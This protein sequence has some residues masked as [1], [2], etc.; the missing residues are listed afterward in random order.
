LNIKAI[1]RSGAVRPSLSDGAIASGKTILPDYYGLDM[2]LAL[3]F[4]LHSP[5]AERIRRYVVG[6]VAAGSGKPVPAI[7][8]SCEAKAAVN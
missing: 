8:L 7:F 3:A 6:R 2:I 5:A 4:W 1:L